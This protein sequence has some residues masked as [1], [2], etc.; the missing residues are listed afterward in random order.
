MD[1]FREDIAG[2]DISFNL[3]ES[4]LKHRTARMANQRLVDKALP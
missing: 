2:G 3:P 1:R 4:P